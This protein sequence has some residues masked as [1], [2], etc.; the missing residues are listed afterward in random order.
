M[1]N[2]KILIVL[3]TIII[4]LFVLFFLF[5]KNTSKNL[6][7]GHNNTSQEIVENILNVSSYETVIE[8]KIEGNKNQNQYKIKQKY[9]GENK[10]EQEVLEPLNIKGTKISREGENLTLENTELKLT[11]VIENYNYISDNRLDLISFVNDY[12][13]DSNSK[14]EEKKEDGKEKI[15][16]CTNYNCKKSLHIDKKTGLPIK[17]EIIDTNKNNKVYILYSEVKIK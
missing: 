3:I 16:M 15:I 1:K 7:T 5:N 2:K 12:K 4:F 17:L 6:K 10:N 8:V 13:K 9:F 11:S 14:Y